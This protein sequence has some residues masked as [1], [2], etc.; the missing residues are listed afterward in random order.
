ML[1]T[2]KLLYSTYILINQP[3]QNSHL[4]IIHLFIN[5]SMFNKPWKNQNIK[6]IKNSSF[7]SIKASI[8]LLTIYT[9]L[10][11]KNHCLSLRKLKNNKSSFKYWGYIFQCRMTYKDQYK[12]CTW[13]QSIQIGILSHKMSVDTI[14]QIVYTSN[15]LLSQRSYTK[16]VCFSHLLLPMTTQNEVKW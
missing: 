10:L 8:K 16:M 3:S 7:T 1:S 9:F 5:W 4:L 14:T 6:N 13:D 12:S 2:Y 15:M 11:R